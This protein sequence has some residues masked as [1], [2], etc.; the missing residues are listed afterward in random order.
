MLKTKPAVFAVGKNYHIMVP[1]TCE[2]LMWVRVGD[3]CYYDEVNGVL[4]SD[5]EIHRMIVPMEELDREKKYTVCA[6]KMI[7]RL[8][9]FT[10]TEDLVEFQFDFRP[11]GG[12]RI[13]AYH[14]SD[15]HNLVDEPVRAAK[16]Y[17]DIDFLIFNGDVPEQSDNIDSILTIYKIAEAVTGGNIPVVFSRGNHDMRGAFAEHFAEW[18]PCENGNSYYTVQLGDLWMLILDCGED[19]P[20]DVDAYGH[21]ICCHTFRRRETKYIESVIANAEKEYQKEGVRRKMVIVHNPFTQQL[22]PP[23]DLEIELYTDWAKLLREQIK[24]DVMLCGHL[25]KVAINEVG[26]EKDMRG[27][28]CT[29]VIGSEHGSDRS[30]P[31]FIKGAGFC[32]AENDIE[33]TFTSC[34]GK[35]FGRY[36]I[37]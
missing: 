31:D 10:Q 36:N 23:F 22:E 1:V 5:T 32:F 3:T 29:V 20:D 9:Y 6:R 14:I 34:S 11:V 26:C 12:D 33:V 17:G 21:T 16:A 27:Q 24:P 18:T 28:P 15:A 19:K 8:P 13:R 2:M 35:E 4:R 30:D 25:H 7:D 37:Q